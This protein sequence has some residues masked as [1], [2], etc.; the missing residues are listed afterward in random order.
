MADV[1]EAGGSQRTLDES[2]L[3]LKIA[4]LLF[5]LLWSGG[6]SAVKIGLAS[7]EPIFFLAVRYVAVLMVLVP[8]YVIFRPALPASPAAWRHLAVVGLL[9]QGL[10]FGGTN[11]A[12]KLG[13]SAAGLALILA[14]QP[15]LV[16][17]LAP[18]MVGEPASARIWLGLVL[19]LAGAVVAIVAK[20]QTGDATPSGIVTAA[21]ALLCITAGTLYEKRFG[22]SHHPII[23]NGV[24]CGVA[25]L[26]SLPLALATEDCRIQWSWPF[27]FSL[28]YLAIGNSIVA[29]TLLFALVRRG[30]AARATALLFLV[31][32]TSALIASHL[33]GETMPPAVWLGMAL[34]AAGVAIVRRA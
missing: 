3:W 22:G 8:A 5:L 25:L 9:I 14:L 10:Y 29:M 7:I 32:P 4:P 24:Q 30:A 1:T 17:V 6:Y 34:A 11:L 28:A 13:A 19:G 12:I 15:I 16:A 31:P 23:A 33:L 26:V 27:V 21:M 2:P 18:R 20:A